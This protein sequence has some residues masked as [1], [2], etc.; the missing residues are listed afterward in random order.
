[1]SSIFSDALGENAPGKEGKMKK[2]KKMFLAL[3]LTAVF[4]MAV[5]AQV[6]Q[7][8]DKTKLVKPPVSSRILQPCEGPDLV[9][10]RPT[11]SKQII[12]G[13]GYLNLSAKVMNQG[14]KDF[15]SNPRQ[16][17]A[18]L[19]VK[20]LW[21]SG[22]GAYVYVQ[23][24]PIAR[25][26]KGQEINLSGRFEL[27]Y[28]RKWDCAE[29]LPGYCCQEIQVL[30]AVSYDPDIRMDSNPDNDDCRAWNERCPDVP[31]HHVWFQVECPW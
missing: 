20:K 19:Y 30:V 23:K 21:M 22:P 8:V 9:A 11:I 12:G 29:V 3:G 26:N 13:K 27:P 28:F 15:I 10:G 2:N 24:I 31:A 18:Q 16:A 7:Q 6:A 5:Y 25:L 17:E 4:A 1:L 14:T